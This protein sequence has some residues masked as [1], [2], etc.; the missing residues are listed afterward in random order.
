MSTIPS[1][2]TRKKTE[3]AYDLIP[4]GDYPARLVRFVGLGIQDQPEFQGQAKQ[5]AFK[6]SFSFEL[7]GMDATG[8]IRKFDS[9]GDLESEE[10][11]EPKPACQF[12]D[13]YLFPG[14]QRGKVFDLCKV[15]DPSLTKVPSELSWFENQLDQIVS[16]TVG[17][18]QVKNGPNKGRYRNTI[19]GVSAIP[20]MFKSQVGEARTDKLFFEPY[21]D[22]QE[23]FAAYSNLYGFHRQILAEAHDATNIPFAGKEPADNGVD[24]QNSEPERQ[25]NTDTNTNGAATNTGAPADFD[26][27]MPF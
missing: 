3:Y 25:P 13:Y 11:M 7:I 2:T 26:D 22:T 27:D 6:A 21:A 17:H 5:P 18:Y 12:G 1:N 23:L 8:K 9:N 19:R 16:V 15:L 14:A 20:G 4:D 10:D 24:G